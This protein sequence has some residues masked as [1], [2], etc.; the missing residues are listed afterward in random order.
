MVFSGDNENVYGDDQLVI[1]M[2]VVVGYLV[3]MIVGLLV[4]VEMG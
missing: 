4:K 3:G 2:L 1:V